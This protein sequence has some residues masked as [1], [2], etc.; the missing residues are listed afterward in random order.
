MCSSLFVGNDIILGR[1]VTVDEHLCLLLQ[2][3]KA[4]KNRRT[5]PSA[6]T[7]LLL[8]VSSTTFLCLAC[9]LHSLL[10]N[11]ALSEL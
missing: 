7:S 10:C 4:N 1:P 3:N 5:K 9:L 11:M 2:K 8:S 6:L